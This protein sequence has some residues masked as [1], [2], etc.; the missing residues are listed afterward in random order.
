MR[1]EV[2][3]LSCVAGIAI[4]RG[5][6]RL[7]PQALISFLKGQFRGERS[8]P[9]GVTEEHLPGPETAGFRQGRSPMRPMSH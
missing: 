9:E 2:P 7:T 1:G 4:V 6:R 3:A 8:D 5:P